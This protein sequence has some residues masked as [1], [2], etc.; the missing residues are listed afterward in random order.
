MWSGRPETFQDRL[1]TELRLAGATTVA[2]ARAVLKQFL[3]RFKPAFWSSGPV[4]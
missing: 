2:Q 3:P 4:S 1:I